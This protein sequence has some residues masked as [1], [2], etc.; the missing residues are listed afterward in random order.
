MKEMDQTHTDLVRSRV[1][2]V[3]MTMVILVMQALTQFGGPLQP[4]QAPVQTLATG[5]LQPQLI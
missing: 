5:E 2:I 4:I 3:S 1:E